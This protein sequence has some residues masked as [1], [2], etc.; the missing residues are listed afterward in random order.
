M[1]YSRLETVY[2]GMNKIRTTT[3]ILTVA[4]FVLA[5][6]PQNRVL[7][8]NPQPTKQ[9]NFFEMSLEDLMEIEVTSAEPASASEENGELSRNAVT[10]YH[11]RV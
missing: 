11:S 6:A 4:I 8:E 7:V 5:I 1:L 3:V 10:I 9:E 2:I